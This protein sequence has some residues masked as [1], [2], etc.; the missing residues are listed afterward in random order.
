MTVEVLRK[1]QK[2]LEG[3]LGST[4]MTVL[5]FF[6]SRPR[7]L[8]ENWSQAV[9]QPGILAFQGLHEAGKITSSRPAWL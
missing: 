7:S 6:S 8:H 5:A 2:V 9:A 4:G 3:Q 1:T